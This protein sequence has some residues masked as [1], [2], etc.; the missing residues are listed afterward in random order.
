MLYGLLTKC[1]VK[2]A[3]Y[4]LS[5]FFACLWTETEPRSINSQKKERGQYPAILIAHLVSKGFIIWL[6]GK[7]FLRDAAGSPERARSSILLAR[8]ASHSAGFDSFCPL[9]ELA[10]HKLRS[11]PFYDGEKLLQHRL[12]KKSLSKFVHS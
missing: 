5:S 10:I 8:V 9:A 6:S 7:I 3:V 2:M 11:W 4:W 12:R 1:E